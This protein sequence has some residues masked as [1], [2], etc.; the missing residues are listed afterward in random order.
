ME[1]ILEYGVLGVCVFALSWVVYRFVLTRMSA[2]C[3]SLRVQIMEVQQKYD[4]LLNQQIN[5]YKTI[6]RQHN[7]TSSKIRRT[8]SS[9][10]EVMQ[11][12]LDRMGDDGGAG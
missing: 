9:S 12:V 5:D 6:V 8:L 11:A 3:E 2:E 1:R 10:T 4:N 7:E